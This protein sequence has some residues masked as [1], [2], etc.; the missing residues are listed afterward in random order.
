MTCQSFQLRI[1]FP[2]IIKILLP[3]SCN[4][5]LFHL[6][7]YYAAHG[8]E[9]FFTVT[10]GIFPSE[11]KGQVSTLWIG[12]FKTMLNIYDGAFSNTSRFL[13]INYSHKKL[14]HRYS[15]VSKIRLWWVSYWKNFNRLILS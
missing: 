1:G 4:N 15:T 2:K 9:T 10:I 8:M 12:A 11:F 7:K 13:A 5:Q 3:Q 14:H 6:P